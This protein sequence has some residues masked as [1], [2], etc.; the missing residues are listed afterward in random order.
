MHGVLFYFTW[1]IKQRGSFKGKQV[2][3]VMKPLFKVYCNM[4]DKNINMINQTDYKS[5][6][7]KMTEY[8]YW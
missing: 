7:E 8:I 4:I 6:E 3:P 1:F 5:L 2:L